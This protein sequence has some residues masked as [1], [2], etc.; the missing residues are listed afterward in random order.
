MDSCV[1]IFDLLWGSDPRVL[2]SYAPLV[3]IDL[4]ASSCLGYRQVGQGTVQPTVYQPGC[5]LA[6][7][8]MSLLTFGLS[9]GFLIL[10]LLSQCSSLCTGSGGSPT[11]NTTAL[12]PL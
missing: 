3:L 7:G 12:C 11:A 9:S 1:R 4:A 5:E 10:G 2:M 6:W 8:N